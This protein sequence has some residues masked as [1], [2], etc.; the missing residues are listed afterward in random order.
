MVGF[1][2]AICMFVAGV[3]IAT[4]G[5]GVMVKCINSLFDSINDGLDEKRREQKARKEVMNK[6]WH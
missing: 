2:G 3:V 6:Q 5:L 1:F 4:R